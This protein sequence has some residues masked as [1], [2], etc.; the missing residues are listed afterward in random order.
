LDRN[1]KY[2]TDLYFDLDS[3]DDEDVDEEEK[4]L[5]KVPLNS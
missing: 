3:S 1:L 2:T 4:V 5:L